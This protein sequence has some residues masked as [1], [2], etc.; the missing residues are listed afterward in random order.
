MGVVEYDDEPVPTEEDL[1]EEEAFVTAAVPE[2]Q[3]AEDAAIMA[4]MPTH[5]NPKKRGR[6]PGK[7][8]KTTIAALNLPS[9]Q[10]PAP[11]EVPPKALQPAGEEGAT[12]TAFAQPASASTLIDHSA[13]ELDG[14]TWEQFFYQLFV[15]K[16]SRLRS[17]PI[18]VDYTVTVDNK[19]C[20][21]GL[22]VDLIRQEYATNGPTLTST[23]ETGADAADLSV[24]K[25]SEDR[26]KALNALGFTWN[27]TTTTAGGATA[28]RS[29]STSANRAASKKKRVEGWT[30]EGADPL[31]NPITMDGEKRMNKDAIWDEMY[32]RLV[33][34]HSRYGHC[35]IPPSFDEK[36][37][38]DASTSAFVLTRDMSLRSWVARQRSLY[39]GTAIAHGKPYVLKPERR[40]LLVALGFDQYVAAGV[41]NL[42]A[43]STTTLLNETPIQ[44]ETTVDGLHIPDPTPLPLHASP[45]VQPP[46]ASSMGGFK[47]RFRK[48]WNEYYE[49]LKEYKNKYGD[50][51]V[52]QFWATD[53]K[54]GKWVAKQRY[55]VSFLVKMVHMSFMKNTQSL[56]ISF[57]HSML[58]YNLKMRNEKS[59]LTD[60][61]MMLLDQI[62]FNWGGI[63]VGSR[64]SG[65]EG[66]LNMTH[67]PMTGATAPFASE[68]VPGGEAFEDQQDV[69]VSADGMAVDV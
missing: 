49:D 65:E 24:L 46:A 59:Q 21:L 52:P 18:P 28:S 47:M 54:L 27:R 12:A 41:E 29:S 57:M 64:T 2:H 66:E 9:I 10:V 44:T 42:N 4:M 36:S 51:N 5:P 56:L 17:I 11:Q 13:L 45:L 62:G 58:Q 26:I 3:Y 30:A 69:K 40:A 39:K 60:P 8:N 23:D 33:L 67:N 37:L 55:Q 6:P 22:W 25:L 35:H 61:R 63:R 20:P 19:A 7:T 53:R 15:Y 1:D 50:C 31:A 14:C 68:E 38:E 43:V 34:Y 48:N 32:Q 16:S